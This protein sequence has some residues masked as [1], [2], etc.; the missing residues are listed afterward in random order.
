VGFEIIRKGPEMIE[1]FVDIA[2]FGK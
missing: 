1:N 2:W